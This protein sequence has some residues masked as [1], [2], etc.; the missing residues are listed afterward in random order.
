[1]L[2]W[3]PGTWGSLAA[4][5]VALASRHAFSTP[6]MV[7]AAFT[8][9]VVGWWAAGVYVRRRDRHDPPE[10]VIDEVAGQWLA[11]AAAPPTL[12]GAAAG[13]VLFRAFDILKP[14]PANWC[15]RRLHGGLGVMADDWVAGGYVFIIMILWDSIYV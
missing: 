3:A 10:V 2:P 13:F 4:L 14:F 5:P 9:F 7:I 8:L 12:A 1:M 15:D 6:Y 11:L